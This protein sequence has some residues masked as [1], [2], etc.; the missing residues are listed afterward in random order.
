METT[1]EY[2]PKKLVLPRFYY[3]THDAQNMDMELSLDEPV[4]CK[5]EKAVEAV[6]AVEGTE[7][8]VAVDAVDASKPVVVA[9]KA[10]KAVNTKR[11]PSAYNI[12]VKETLAVLTKTH[13]HMTS[14]ERFSLAIQMWNDQKKK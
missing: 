12:Y 10:V 11:A 6:E 4:I 1:T 5:V 3:R 8:A 7:T 13:S 9:A 14:K 2:Q